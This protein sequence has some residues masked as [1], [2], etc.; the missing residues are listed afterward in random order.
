VVV[1]SAEAVVGSGAA[2]KGV[3]KSGE[4]V[5]EV[6]GSDEVEGEAI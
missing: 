3:E 5:S 4:G 1:G 2:E 6:D